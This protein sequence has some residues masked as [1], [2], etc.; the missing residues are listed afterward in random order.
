MAKL[1]R[2]ISQAEKDDYDASGQ[3]RTGKNTLEAKQFFK[4]PVAVKQFVNSSVLQA[5]N[6][7]YVYL[8][9][10][11]IDDDLIEQA[12]PTNMKLDGYEAMNIA[13]EDL[14]TFNNCITFVDEEAL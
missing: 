13:E 2:A 5:Y 4:S 10:I 6:P 1:Y 9:T 8:L 7:P 12:N 14:I 11:T 3:F